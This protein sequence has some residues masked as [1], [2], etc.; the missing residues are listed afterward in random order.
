MTP[1]KGRVCLQ[2]YYEVRRCLYILEL[3]LC[4]KCDYFHCNVSLEVNEVL[5]RR[6]ILEVCAKIVNI[7]YV[8]HMKVLSIP[9]FDLFCCSSLLFLFFILLQNKFFWFISCYF[10]ASYS[11]KNQYFIAFPQREFTRL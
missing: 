10:I 4:Q 7:L 1:R 8:I 9:G 5:N 11:E 2:N 6:Q 3:T